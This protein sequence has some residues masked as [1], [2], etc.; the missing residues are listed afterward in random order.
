M[1]RKA[2]RAVRELLPRER[3]WLEIGAGPGHWGPFPDG[4]AAA[5]AWELHGEV[6]L[7]EGSPEGWP[8]WGAVVFGAAPPGYWGRALAQWRRES[9]NT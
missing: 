8:P 3:L 4:E 6:L 5:E 1:P 2:R 9:E 7:A